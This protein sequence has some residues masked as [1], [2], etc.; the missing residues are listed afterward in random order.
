MNH[1]DGLPRRH[2]LPRFQYSGV[3][4]PLALCAFE[5]GCGEDPLPEPDG[6]LTLTSASPSR[7]STS[8]TTSVTLVEGFS[9]ISNGIT[10]MTG[11]IVTNDFATGRINT[12]ACGNDT[13]VATK[14]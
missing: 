4:G 3:V 6:V 12:A 7:G 14:A 11:G 9:V 13:W 1:P 10:I 8:G 5:V 2:H